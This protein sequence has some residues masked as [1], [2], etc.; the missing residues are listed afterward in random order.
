TTAG[1][2]GVTR[3]KR[4]GTVHPFASRPILEPAPRGPIQKPSSTE[5][6]GPT[7]SPT[8]KPHQ[9]HQ[10]RRHPSAPCAPVASTA[11]T[12]RGT[13]PSPTEAGTGEEA[14]FSPIPKEREKRTA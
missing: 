1:R 3:S 6:I 5:P 12:G 8:D 4:I 2:C 7:D 11:R 9:P 14:P 13:V 10:R